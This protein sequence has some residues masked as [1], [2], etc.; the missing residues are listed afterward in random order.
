MDKTFNLETKYTL[1]IEKDFVVDMF[2]KEF[3]AL[4]DLEYCTAQIS[5]G[6]NNSLV[7][8]ITKDF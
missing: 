6:K 3:T 5:I 8:T 2:V 7:I 4:E 1:R